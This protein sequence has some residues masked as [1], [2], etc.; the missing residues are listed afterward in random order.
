MSKVTNALAKAEETKRAATAKI[1]VTIGEPHTPTQQKLWKEVQALEEVLSRRAAADTA[2]HPARSQQQPAAPAQPAT[3][4]AEGNAKTAPP[5]HTQDA[6][7]E[8]CANLKAWEQMLQRVQSQLAVSEQ[9]A[10][11]NAAERARLQARLAANNVLMEEADRERLALERQVIEALNQADA[12][13]ASR[14]SWHRR[15]EALRACQSLVRE[16]HAAEQ[17]L[18]INAKAVES[19]LQAQQR[20]TEQLAQCRQQGEALRQRAEALRAQVEKA[21][22][23]TGSV[24]GENQ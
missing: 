7:Q 23:A 3:P 19:L 22:A 11:G 9:Q 16:A 1:Q 10:A 6:T 17:E 12:I 8:S 20:V 4:P 24:S 15:L 14:A 5:P 2:A 13:E 18:E 21:L